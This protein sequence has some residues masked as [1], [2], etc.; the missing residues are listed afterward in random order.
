MD[1]GLLI[2]LFMI[3]TLIYLFLE[4]RKLSNN[5]ENNL[6]TYPYATDSPLSERNE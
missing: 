3:F 4:N 2:V 6:K 1:W 5:V